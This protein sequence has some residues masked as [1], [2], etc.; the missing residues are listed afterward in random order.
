MSKN[1]TFW[2]FFLLIWAGGSTYWHVC[3]IKQLCDAQTTTLPVQENFTVTPLTIKDGIDLDL[4]S[5]GNFAFAKSGQN[6]DFF[7]VKPELDSLVGYL[8]NNPQKKVNLTGYYSLSES[9]P[10]G[11]LNLG[12]ARAEKVKAYLIKLGLPDS[13]LIVNGELFET[14]RFKGDTL[15]GGI[16]FGFTAPIIS[17]SEV[18]LA[19]AESF[20]NVFKP[21]DL[22]FSSGSSAY[23]KTEA[24]SRFLQEAVDYLNSHKTQ[25]LI[26]TGY[27]DNT[28]DDEMNNVLSKKR[29]AAVKQE[30]V[31]AG[32]ATSQVEIDGKGERFPKETNDTE[33]GRKANRRVE[34]VVK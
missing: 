16:S 5:K 4:V 13:V 29:A 22:Y 23:I 30:F 28:G 20:E 34:I 3:K 24:N 31:Q 11:Y 21:M 17:S 27:T 9:A 26:L 10:S 18:E 12:I 32:I 7:G 2:W 19:K 15:F 6:P 25:K 14:A 8:R 33:A 1:N